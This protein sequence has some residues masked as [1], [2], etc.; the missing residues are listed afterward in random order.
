MSLFDEIECK[1]P[2]PGDVPEFLKKFP[3]FQTHDLGQGMNEYEIS[4]QGEIFLVHSALFGLIAGAFGKSSEDIR[5]YE[6]KTPMIWK[7]KKIHMHA[8]NIRGGS[9]SKDGYVYYTDD[10]SDYISINYVVQIRD[11]KV[12]SIKETGRSV[13]PAKKISEMK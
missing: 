4:E 3:L 8:S 2:L 10:G 1:M 7:R 12:S 5:N 13:Q 6:S 9:P 11:G